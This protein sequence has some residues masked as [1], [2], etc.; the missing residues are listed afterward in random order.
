M[1]AIKVHDKS[2]DIYLSEA[3]IQER[4]GELAASI[5]RDYAGKRP[6]FIAVLNGSFMF[7]SD[8]FKQLTIDA[9]ICFI[10]LASYKGMKSSGNVVTSI[11]LDDDIFGKDVIIVEDI[12]DTGKTLHDFLPK[13]EHQQ[14]ASMRIAT[15]LHKSEATTYPLALDY[16]GF[17][18]PNKFVVGYGLDYD[19]LGRNLKEIYQLAG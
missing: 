11:G 16:V 8:L 18:I 4:I 7:A 9:E 12:V 19:G 13:L 10:K 6:F 2:F 3:T 14:P 5:N 17:D 15:L 1:G